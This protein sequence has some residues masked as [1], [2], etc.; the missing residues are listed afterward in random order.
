M[1]IDSKLMKYVI[2]KKRTEHEVREKC[3]TL[4]YTSDYIER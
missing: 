2:F 4:N 1:I 3:K